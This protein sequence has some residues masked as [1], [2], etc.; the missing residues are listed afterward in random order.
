MQG[1]TTPKRNLTTEQRSDAIA[2]APRSTPF[3]LLEP[4]GQFRAILSALPPVRSANAPTSPLF[5]CY[6]T[7][8]AVAIPIGCTAASRFPASHGRLMLRIISRLS[9]LVSFDVVVSVSRV[10]ALTTPHD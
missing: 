3:S 4:T 7:D 9:S 10:S 8:S 6:V 5:P 1:T 2:V